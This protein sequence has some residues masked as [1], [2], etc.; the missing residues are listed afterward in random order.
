ME[1]M[2]NIGSLIQKMLEGVADHGVASF[3]RNFEKE[4]L[5]EVKVRALASHLMRL[6]NADHEEFG[7]GIREAVSA[8]DVLRRVHP[9][10]NDGQVRT[11]PHCP[12]TIW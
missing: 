12:W 8:I 6:T 9:G 11:H 2:A 1:W 3:I 7:Q 5:S 10:Q 4:K